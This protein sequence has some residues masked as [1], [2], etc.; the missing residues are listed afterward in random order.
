MCASKCACSVA[1][2]VSNSLRPHEMQ[3]TRL[4][5][6]WDSPGK[7]TGVGCH[8]LLQGIFPTQGSNPGISYVSCFGRWVLYH[9]YHLGNSSEVLSTF[10]ILCDHTHHPSPDVPHF[11]QMKLC[12]HETIVPR[13]PLPLAL[14]LSVPGLRLL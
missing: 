1:S 9:W 8:A 10:R 14:L 2:G 3:P 12:T 6:S 13:P 7:I 4:L 5:C 11:P